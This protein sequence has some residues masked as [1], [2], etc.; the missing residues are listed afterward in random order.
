M[1]LS[2]RFN[3]FTRIEFG[4]GVTNKLGE[5]A[6]ELKSTKAMIITD[7][8][9]ERTGIID[10][11]R[12]PLE[13]AG[14]EVYVFNEAVGNPPIEVVD[15]GAELLEK[16]EAEMLVG[17]G[18][19]SAMDTSKG[20]GVVEANGGSIKDYKLL[21]A[22]PPPR[23][24]EKRIKPLIT[25]PTTAGTGAEVT[26][27]GVITDREEKVKFCFAGPNCA[28]WITLV[29]PLNTVKMP[30]RLTAGTGMDALAHAVE[31]YISIGSSPKHPLTDAI[32]IEAIKL[33]SE[34]LRQAVA[35]GENIEARTNMSLAALMAGMGFINAGLTLNHGIAMILGARHNIH[36]GTAC[37]SL[38]PYVMEF[39]LIANPEKFINIARAMGEKTEGLSKVAAAR[40]SIEAMKTLCEDVGVPHPSKLGIKEEDIEDIAK[41]IKNPALWDPLGNPRKFTI[42]DVAELL[43]K[44]VSS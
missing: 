33:T 42:E 26:W 32:L 44:A 23:P 16:I 38:L 40:K 35:N 31:G 17:V 8:G 7:R 29:D 22:G 21:T 24:M 30:P 43:R 5:Y 28:P 3:L 39:N 12:A 11:V 4:I 13:E 2:F 15:K 20:I 36:H 34:N 14:V 18:G 1:D 6:K 25:I 27:A 37:G 19:G 41:E 10:A 9:V